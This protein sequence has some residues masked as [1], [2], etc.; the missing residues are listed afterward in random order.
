V[1][2]PRLRRAE[3]RRAKYT[4]SSYFGRPLQRFRLREAMSMLIHGP[5]ARAAFPGVVFLAFVSPSRPWAPEQG[6]DTVPPS[7]VTD[8]TLR[9]IDAPLVFVDDRLEGPPFVLRWTSPGD[10]ATQGTAWR[11][12]A[13]I[14]FLPLDAETWNSAILLAEFVP[15]LPSP[16]GEVDSIVI[17]AF[18]GLEPGTRYEIALRTYDEVGNVSPLSNVVRWVTP[19]IAPV[20]SDTVDIGELQLW[21]C[22]KRIPG[23]V[24]VCEYAAHVVRVGGQTCPPLPMEYDLPEDMMKKVYGRVPFV[25]DLVAQGVS[26]REAGNRFNWTCSRL[27]ETAVRAAQRNGRADFATE[28]RA[29]PL[30]DRVDGEVWY[31]K[32]MPGG[33]QFTDDFMAYKYAEPGRGIGI[34]LST[35]A[36]NSETARELFQTIRDRARSHSRYL[37]IKSNGMAFD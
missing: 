36:P 20:V 4:V 28:L 5:W 24:V 6:R 37:R 33:N 30:I 35:R 29:S 16:S 26:Y 7:P 23:P 21:M 14:H 2:P 32:G 22:S 19:G 3:L 12:D 17:D 9:G 34:D 25:Q 31:W 18:D 27:E 13:R 1:K 10:D 15:V 8:L 11:Y